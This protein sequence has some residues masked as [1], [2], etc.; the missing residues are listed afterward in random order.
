MLRDV[1]ATTVGVVAVAL[2]YGP[3]HAAAVLIGLW[4][5]Y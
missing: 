1:L 2:T 5:L 3:V 4:Y